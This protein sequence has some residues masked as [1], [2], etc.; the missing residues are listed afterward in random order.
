MTKRF[1]FNL[2]VQ[3][4]SAIVA[5]VLAIPTLAGFAWAAY[6]VRQEVAANTSWR[7]IQTWERLEAIR[8]RRQLSQVE[9]AAWCQ[10]GKDLGVF[11]ECPP[12]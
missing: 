11:E 1:N 7:L 8:K 12:R 9:W 2:S 3:T 5:I 6:E 4:I 10:A